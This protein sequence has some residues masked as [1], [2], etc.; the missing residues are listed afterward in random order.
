MTKSTITREQLEEWVAQFDEDGGCDATDRQLEALIRQSLAAMDSE[1]A[2]PVAEVVSI[3]GD[4]EAFGEREI[5]PLVGIQQMPYGTKLYR[6]AQ[7]A[8]VVPD[9]MTAI[10]KDEAEYVEGWNACR[11]AML[12]PDKAR[13][14]IRV[15]VLGASIGAGFDAT[16]SGYSPAQSDCCPA[17]NHVSPEQNGDTP[18][19]SQGW[20]PVSEQ[21]PPSRHEVLVGRWWGEKPRWCCKWATYIPGHPD[22]QSSGWLI[23]GASWTP[24]HWMP[25]PAAPQEV[26]GE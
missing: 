19:Q 7:P 4:P 18:A 16:A 6:H 22:S 9:K 2:A 17:Q 3:Y 8:P 5:R 15:I 20:I 1:P 13:K 11:A 12:N 26:K 23:P 14:K 25:L 21:M 10:V 24:T